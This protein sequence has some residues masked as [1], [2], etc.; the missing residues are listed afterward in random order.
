MARLSAGWSPKSLCSCGQ[1]TTAKLEQDRTCELTIICHLKNLM[2]INDMRSENSGCQSCFNLTQVS[3]LQGSGCGCPS[4]SRSRLR[5]DRKMS[6]ALGVLRQWEKQAAAA[7]GGGGTSGGASP[8]GPCSRASRLLSAADIACS[9]RRPSNTH[10][11]WL[12]RL[13]LCSGDGYMY[14]HRRQIDSTCKV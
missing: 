5:S 13:H 1:Q 6:S 2:N 12:C 10:F 11:A 3:L 7:A 8:G 4:N 14:Q 9:N